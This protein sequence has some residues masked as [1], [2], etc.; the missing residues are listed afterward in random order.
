MGC[1]SCD[2]LKVLKL[3]WPTLF[4]L[5]QL[6]SLALLDRQAAIFK[7]EL[8]TVKGLEVKPNLKS[9][10]TPCFHCSRSVPYSIKSK[11]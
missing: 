1:G 11:V 2:W 4:T 10:A 5:N 3:D 7:E 9:D 6:S 8:G